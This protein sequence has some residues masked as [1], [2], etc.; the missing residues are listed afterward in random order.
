MYK[1]IERIKTGY[2]VARSFVI[3]H[4]RHLPVVALITGFLLDSL[5]LNRLDQVFDNLVITFYLVVAGGVIAFLNYKEERMVTPSLWW[6]VILQF[7]FGNLASALFVIFGKSGTL[8]GSW[9]FLLVFLLLLLGNEFLRG[10]YTRLRLNIALF[11]LFLL[12]YLVLVIPVLARAIGPEIFIV[13][14]LCSLMVMGVWF[15]IFYM[16]APLRIAEDRKQLL[17]V[18]A[19]VFVGFNIFYFL[20]LVPPA[21]LVLKDIGIY[22]SVQRTTEDLYTVS[23]EGGVWYQPFKRSDN[24]FHLETAHSAFCFSSVFAPARISAP[25]VHRWEYFDTENKKWIMV[26]D[27]AFPI[28]GGRN[29]GFRG[30][31]ELDSLFVGK[32]R[33]SVETERGELIGRRSFTV[34]DGGGS[35]MLETAFR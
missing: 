21:P 7:S 25:I 30:Y 23:F 10:H 29:G 35:S 15:G 5:T 6:T 19:L 20:H 33:C 32:W 1:H 4:R 2:I 27:I 28:T 18:V 22:H 16:V 12:S 26:A 11:Y 8:V 24:V 13:S 14:G 17:T 9:P 3:Q 34:V 31:S